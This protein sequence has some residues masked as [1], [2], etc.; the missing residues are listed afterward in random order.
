MMMMM[1]IIPGYYDGKRLNDVM[2]F[3]NFLSK[4][5]EVDFTNLH[6]QIKVFKF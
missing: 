2:I 1:I 5:N 4:S 3:N 6:R